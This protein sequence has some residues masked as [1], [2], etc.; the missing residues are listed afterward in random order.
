MATPSDFEV[1]TLALVLIITTVATLPL[2][3]KALAPSKTEQSSP[4]MDLKA[5]QAPRL[6]GLALSLFAKVTRIPILGKFILQ[7]IKNDNDFQHVRDFAATLTHLVPLYLPMQPP[8]AEV[9]AEH[10][11]LAASFS[12]EALADTPIDVKEDGSF[13]RWTIHDYTSRYKAGTATPSQVI[14][15]VLDAIDASNALSPP[16]LAF[17][18]VN[19][20]AVLQE[21]A[22]ATERYARGTPL[23]VLDGVPVAVKDEV[24]W[25]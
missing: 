12:I 19:R 10:T 4:V 11:Q 23:G 1:P 17:I 25:I 15:A 5:I 13:R 9:L 3:Y 21:A 18:K 20:D 16:L 2:V 8:S 7:S 6:T 14:T 22:A 24:C